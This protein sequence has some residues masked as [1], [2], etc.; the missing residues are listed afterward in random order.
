MSPFRSLTTSLTLVLATSSTLAWAADR[1]TPPLAPV[2]ANA[3]ALELA[4]G[5]SLLGVVSVGIGE[6]SRVAGSKPPQDYDLSHPVAGWGIG[7]A[8]VGAGTGLG[9]ALFID[10]QPSWIGA[11]GAT[12]ISLAIGTAGFLLMSRVSPP[13]NPNE[14]AFGAVALTMP[15]VTSLAGSLT[16]QGLRWLTTPLPAPTPVPLQTPW[17]SS[18]PPVRLF[19]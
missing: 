9:L 7:G 18:S 14:L 15:F 19:L 5:G 11:A 1:P 13:T 10:P 17:P 6:A 3:F 2:Q 16:Y 8:A 4:L 12:L